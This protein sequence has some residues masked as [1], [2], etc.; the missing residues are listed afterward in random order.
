MLHNV[1]FL[2]F[3]DQSNYFELGD[4][5]VQWGM[6]TNSNDAV[7]LPVEMADSNYSICLSPQYQEDGQNFW[8]A[9]IFAVQPKAFAYRVGW[10]QV[11]G[12]SGAKVTG[13][14][15]RWIVIGRKASA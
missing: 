4:I 5:V 15:V 14:T 11:N 1:D 9:H 7:F 3:S 10:Q 2:T 6:A 12:Q 13:A 8:W